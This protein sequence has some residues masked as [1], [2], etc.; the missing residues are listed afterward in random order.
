MSTGYI[1]LTTL[2]LGLRFK[3]LNWSQAY[4]RK[5]F[6]KITINSETPFFTTEVPFK[7]MK[8]GFKVTEAPTKYRPRSVGTTSLGNLRTARDMFL[9]MIK[10]RFGLLD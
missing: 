5:I 3:D 10:L 1:L 6:N 9:D 2:I 7:A 4:R 8:A